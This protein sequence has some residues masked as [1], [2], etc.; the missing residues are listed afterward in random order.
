MAEGTGKTIRGRAVE[1]AAIEW[2]MAYE[3]AQGRTPVDKRYV[4]DFSGD[5]E[6]PPRIIELKSTATSYRG[7][8]LPL[9]PVQFDHAGTDPNFYIYVVENVGQAD[10]AEFTLRILDPVHLARLKERFAERHYYE[11]SWPTADYDAT[12][13]ETDT[14]GTVAPTTATGLSAGS[15]AGPVSQS[16]VSRAIQAAAV[17]LGGEGSLTEIV[18]AV[19]TV[20]P[21]RWQDLPTSIADHAFPGS[22]S[23]PVPPEQRIIERVARG[24]YRLRADP[25]DRS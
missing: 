12:G 18:A 20:Q 10:P 23:S 8:F 6:S 15:S 5:L 9:E 13:M 4:R 2:V 25:S 22:A 11:V 24:R 17:G 19:E 3:C 16:D 14:G 7:W 21:G 1:Q